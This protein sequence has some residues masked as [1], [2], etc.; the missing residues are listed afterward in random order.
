MQDQTHKLW[1]VPGGKPLL[2]SEESAPDDVK[3]MWLLV[4][5][6]IYL[7]GLRLHW[8]HQ[9]EKAAAEFSYCEQFCRCGD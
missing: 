8:N 2:L 6:P 5:G 7:Q 9:V 3:V 1:Q 4:G